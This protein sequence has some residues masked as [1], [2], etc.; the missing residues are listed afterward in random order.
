MTNIDGEFDLRTIA[1]T[2]PHGL[3]I[4][5][6]HD[7]YRGQHAEWT[8]R[9]NDA[10]QSLRSLGPTPHLQALLGPRWEDIVW[11][12]FVTL[13]RDASGATS[14]TYQGPMPAVTESTTSTPTQSRS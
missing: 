3:E 1:D 12:K 5:K 10:R 9:A 13:Q 6:N 14:G 4:T 8:P 11:L 7:K 2:S